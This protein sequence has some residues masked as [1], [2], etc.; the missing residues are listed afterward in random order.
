MSAE[1]LFFFSQISNVHVY[2]V[3]Q[4]QRNMITRKEPGFKQ[5]L[6]MNGAAMKTAALR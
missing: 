6:I 5:S 2:V 1:I 3:V 4:E